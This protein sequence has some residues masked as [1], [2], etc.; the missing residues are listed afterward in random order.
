MLALLMEKLFHQNPV[1]I[2]FVY[3]MKNQDLYLIRNF[4]CKNEIRQSQS[5]I[6]HQ[7]MNFLLQFL[8]RID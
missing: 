1:L 2:P 4:F 7:C 6:F 5:E 8:K 3:G